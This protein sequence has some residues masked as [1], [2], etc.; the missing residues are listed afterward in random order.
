MTK[1]TKTEQQWQQLAVT[2]DDKLTALHQLEASNSEAAVARLAELESAVATHLSDLGQAL[3][4]PMS[5]LIDS[6]SEAPKAAAEVIE[7]LRSEISKN[8]ERDNDL[9]EERARTME[10]LN[11]LSDSLQTTLTSQHDIVGNMVT[12]SSQTLEAVAGQFSEHVQSETGKLSEMSD[13]FAASAIEMAS[14][15]EAFSSAVNIFNNANDSMLT[16]M[17]TIQQAI[18][19]QTNRSDEQLAYYVAQ[20]REII[21][22]GMLTQQEVMQQLKLLSQGKLDELSANSADQNAADEEQA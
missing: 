21:D 6:A 13:Q 9:L 19:A 16:Q 17:Q 10:D 12:A 4:A 7:Q 20:A 11:K 15:G 2:L 5:R 1:I 8:I 18:E 3:E 22:H 14:L